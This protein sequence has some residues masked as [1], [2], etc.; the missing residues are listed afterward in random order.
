MIVSE[1]LFM[2]PPYELTNRIL[3][4]IASISEKIGEVNSANL[5]KPP[6]EL[7]KKNRIKTIHSSLII[8]GN[9]L[10]EDQITAIFGNKKVIGPQKDIIEVQNAIK[11]YDRINEFNP[12][13]LDSFCKAHSILMKDLVA[14]PGK[15]RTKPVGIIKGKELA[16]LAPPSEIVKPLM[17]DLF[18]YLKN[19]KDILLIKSCVFHYE[20]E[21]IHPFLDGNGRMG[22]FW[23]AVILNHKY[24]VFE[25]LPVETIICEKQSGYYN[26]LSK[27]DKDGKSTV[28]I[29]FMLEVIDEALENLLK[30]QNFSVGQKDR[31][32]LAKDLF[33]VDSF[34]RQEYLRFFKKISTATASRDL[35]YGVDEG[36]L[37][38][39]GDKRLTKY[40]FKK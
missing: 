10:T 6:T 25:F 16:H 36:Y 7:R 23:Q 28:F 32:I 8:E 40:K 30:S 31:L 14:A 26:S 5:Q 21:F 18:N 11:L 12:L 22:R 34:T 37:E 13:G 39:A 27:S 1:L 19:D 4:L 24:P 15:L 2:K 20:T 38:K 17:T 33:N 35:K 29:E 9:T 3:A